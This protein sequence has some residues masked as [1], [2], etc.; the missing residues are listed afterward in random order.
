MEVLFPRRELIIAFLVSLVKEVQIAFTFL[1]C[2]FKGGRIE[3]LL[4]LH[5]L[6]KK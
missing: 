6:R 2:V 5:F 4:Y 1:R 3:D